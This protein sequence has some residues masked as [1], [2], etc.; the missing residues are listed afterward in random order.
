MLAWSVEASV[1]RSPKFTHIFDGKPTPD[2]HLVA[3]FGNV[4]IACNAGLLSIAFGL[5]VKLDLIQK[6]D[7]Q[8]RFLKFA[9]DVFA[10]LL[11]NVF[12]NFGDNF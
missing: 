5:P 6:P 3:D 12:I 4:F 10:K 11:S 9:F 2:A 1:A 7:K 8:V